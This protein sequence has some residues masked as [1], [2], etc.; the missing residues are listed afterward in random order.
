MKQ[1]MLWLILLI[2]PLL[3]MKTI[4]SQI[5]RLQGAKNITEENITVQM[6]DWMWS[7][8]EEELIQENQMPNQ[9][10]GTEKDDHGLEGLAANLEFLMIK[11]RLS[12]FRQSR[13]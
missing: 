1:A 12:F 4:P 7:N 3:A 9:E 10:T 8:T 6:E 11:V 5:E 2:T 13:A